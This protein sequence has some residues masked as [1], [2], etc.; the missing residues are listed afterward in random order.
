MKWKSTNEKKWCNQSINQSISKSKHKKN[1]KK[2][3]HKHREK[4]KCINYIYLHDDDYGDDDET[5]HP[6][7][8]LELI[9][10]CISSLVVDIIFFSFLISSQYI[11]VCM[12]FISSKSCDVNWVFTDDDDGDDEKKGK[13]CQKHH[14]HTH[15]H[16][17]T[18]ITYTDTDTIII[19]VKFREKKTFT[20]FL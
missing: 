9:F 16:T 15:T 18:Y 7:G 13:I 2:T 1:E 17:Q 3:C 6:V 12:Y 20:T 14:H 8:S 5:Y 4:Q 10:L 11:C 19:I